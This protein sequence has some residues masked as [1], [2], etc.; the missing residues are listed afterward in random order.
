MALLSQRFLRHRKLF[1]DRCQSLLKG[2]AAA[3]PI[4]EL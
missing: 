3:I 2:P 1:L 4:A